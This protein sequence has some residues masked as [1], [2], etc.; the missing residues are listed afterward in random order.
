LVFLKIW[1]KKRRDFKRQLILLNKGKKKKI[2]SD[3]ANPQK[4]YTKMLINAFL[5]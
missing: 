5:K 3:F 4:E 2:T 1:I